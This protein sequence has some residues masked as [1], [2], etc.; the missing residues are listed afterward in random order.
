MISTEYIKSSNKIV[1]A[2]CMEVLTGLE[3]SSVDLIYI[4]PPLIGD[5]T[6]SNIRTTSMRDDDGD[7]TVYQPGKY[8]TLE[9]G[10][11][12]YNDQFDCYAK[13]LHPI[14]KEAYRVLA[15]DGT[16]Y[17]HFDAEVMTVVMEQMDTIFGENGWKSGLAIRHKYYIKL[18]TGCPERVETIFSYVKDPHK[19]VSNV[20]DF[21]PGPCVALWLND[22]E[23]SRREKRSMWRRWDKMNQINRNERTGYPNQKPIGLLKQIITASS[24]PG[25]LVLDFFAGSGTTGDAAIQLDRRF[26]LV[27]NNPAAVEVMT[28]RFA[29]YPGIEFFR[30]APDI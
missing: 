13:F 2:D 25:D 6:Q 5:E 9:S 28:K 22:T 18:R 26:L 17:L 15:P 29:K 21:G 12:A 30:F 3:G 24:N 20:A 8:Q 11:S 16:M 23:K 4:D 7:R 19:Y 14:L 27:D 10:E 1:Q